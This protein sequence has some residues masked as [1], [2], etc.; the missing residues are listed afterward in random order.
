V[1]A[2]QFD[3]EEQR[4]KNRS[5]VTVHE[6]ETS[7]SKALVLAQSRGAQQAT[8]VSVG[9]RAQ[10]SADRL[11][12]GA[13][14]ALLPIEIP[15]GEQPLKPVTA[16]LFCARHK[17][18]GRRVKAFGQLLLAH[19]PV[20]AIE[21][22]KAVRKL[23]DRPQPHIVIPAPREPPGSIGA[24]TSA[25]MPS[26]PSSGNARGDVIAPRFTAHRIDADG[27]TPIPIQ[28]DRELLLSVRRQ[29]GSL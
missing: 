7:R 25:G 23:L 29:I 16:F 12:L 2:Y 1:T 17:L 28:V 3:T 10:Q 26:A 22:V 9:K 21:E 6:Q 19:R 27:T 24:R 14:V 5:K 8:I 20:S 4:R 15:R 11:Q 13:E 18:R